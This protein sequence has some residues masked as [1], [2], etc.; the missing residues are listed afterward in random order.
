[1]PVS[2]RD[3]LLASLRQGQ[4]GFPTILGTPEGDWI[5]FKQSHYRLAE[6]RQRIELAKDVSGFANAGGGVIVVGI[7]TQ[8]L[9]NQHIE[10]A[11]KLTPVRMAMLNP[12]R[13]RD[14][15]RQYVYPRIDGLACSTFE[16]SEDKGILVIEIP[17]QD[18]EGKPFVVTEGISEEGEHYGN[19]FGWFQREGD[20]I[21]PALPSFIHDL[22]RDG[23]RLRRMLSDSTPQPT[24][25]P[26]ALAPESAAP[27][28]LSEEK[29]RPRAE[30]DA[31]DLQVGDAPH[32]VVQAWKRSGFRLPD[33]HG[34]FKRNFLSPPQLRVYGFNVGFSQ[35][36]EVLEGGG[37]R[38]ARPGT[39]SLSALPNGLSTL[40]G[41]SYFLGWAMGDSRSWGRE[42]INPVPLVELIYEFC[43]FFSTYVR[44]ESNGP[45][46][47]VQARL[48]RLDVEGARRLA[49]GDLHRLYGFDDS[50]LPGGEA[51]EIVTDIVSQE[52][53]ERAAFELLA[54]IY[55][56]YGLSEDAIP[57][58]DTET[59]VV[60]Q[61]QLTEQRSG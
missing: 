57:F 29:R 6:K 49:P 19:M 52:A 39:V 33:I 12:S 36:L 2:N 50:K 11:F 24:P 48:C 17:K 27:D 46:M 14:V 60:S 55:R 43:R 40:V 16:V 61:T 51:S 23:F 9:P 59:R 4:P 44:D 10:V 37:L 22:L 32:L 3:E 1:M 25:Q 41:G 56:Q 28:V 15:L 38:K 47:N 31:A 35:G 45:E 58:T 53:P 30:D 8:R 5:D 18:S 42:L 26:T 20:S 7:E 13:V 54:D 34:Q 21:Q